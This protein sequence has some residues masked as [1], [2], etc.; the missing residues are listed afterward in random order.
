MTNPVP[1]PVD[2]KLEHKFHHTIRA[3]RRNNKQVAKAHQVWQAQL[4]QLR[5]EA[6]FYQNFKG[7]TSSP[8]LLVRNGEEVITAFA[9][10]IIEDRPGPTSYVG[11]SSGLSVPV[12][13]IGGASIRYNIGSSRGQIVHGAPVET[14]IDTGTVYITNQRV[15]FVGSKQTRD[16]EFKNLASINCPY[17]NRTVL[18]LTNKDKAVILA[19]QSNM[20]FMIQRAML[21][22]SSMFNGNRDHLVED[23]N[24]ELTQ[25]T[26]AEPKPIAEPTFEDFAS[27]KFTPLPE[28]TIGQEVGQLLSGNS[29][30][31]KWALA[32]GITSILAGSV[33]GIGLAC[34]LLG[35]FFAI[36]SFRSGNR[37]NKSTVWGVV[38]AA[39][40]LPI[41][42]LATY[43]GVCLL[44][45]IP[46]SK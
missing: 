42:A 24:A 29:N 32:F 10:G 19:Y 33:P 35:I 8:N 11:R 25:L 41:S 38:L 16:V 44:L 5:A 7:E 46:I 3:I 1:A 13:K 34:S 21:L 36:K 18:S 40:A 45:G 37:G 30:A 39:L 23:T 20:S 12:A 26:A 28:H 17:N 14:Q 15:V 31:N 9:C 22:A 2:K 6:E 4:E 27:G 43:G